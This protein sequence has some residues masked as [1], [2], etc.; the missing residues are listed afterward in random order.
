MKNYLIKTKNKLHIDKL[1]VNFDISEH[2]NVLFKLCIQ[3]RSIF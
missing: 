3:F 2:Q 1:K